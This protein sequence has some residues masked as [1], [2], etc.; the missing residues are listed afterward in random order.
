MI[1]GIVIVAFDLRSA[2]QRTDSLTSR[3]PAIPIHINLNTK[4]PNSSSYVYRIAD[5]SDFLKVFIFPCF[6]GVL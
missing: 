1:A 2:S 3:L 6:Y 4:R 5:V